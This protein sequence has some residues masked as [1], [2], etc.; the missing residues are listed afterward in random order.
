MDC[1]GLDITAAD[2]TL[3]GIGAASMH[4]KYVGS[5]AER[6]VQ[7]DRQPRSGRMGDISERL[8]SIKS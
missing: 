7:T 1:Y 6:C 8:M 2:A 4:L 3:L 5:T